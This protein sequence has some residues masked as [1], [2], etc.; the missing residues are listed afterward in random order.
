MEDFWTSALDFL[1]LSAFLIVGMI[2]KNKIRFLQKYLIPTSIIAGFIGLILG[3]EVLK[4]IDLDPDRLGV[5]IYH[6]MAVGFIALALKERRPVDGGNKR[7]NFNTGFAIVSSYLLQGIVGF[8]ISLLLAYTVFPDLFPPFG[9]LLPLGFGQGPGQAFSIGSSWELLGLIEG[10]NIGISIATIGFLW[11]IIFGIPLT[12]FLVR[13][14][15]RLGLVGKKTFI[16]KSSAKYE[17]KHTENI[18]KKLSLDSLAV[19]LA[20]IGFVYMLTYFLLKG[21]A[22][23][24]APLGTY[25]ETVTSLLWGFQFVIGTMIAIGVRVLLTVF[26]RKNWLH[27]NYPD[28]Y[29][30]QRVSSTS[31][32]YMIVA[33]ISAISIVTFR[34]NWIPILVIT[35]IGGIITIF[36]S[37]FLSRRIYSTYKVEH[38]VSLF[39]MLTGTI[40]T[41]VALLKEVDPDFKSNAAENLVLGSAVAL[42]LGLPLMFLL[43]FAVTGYTAGKPEFYF[44]TLGIFVLYMA[45]LLAVMLWK[46]KKR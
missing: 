17:E 40:T 29:I 21:I 10:G 3:Q 2:L 4:L 13:R 16:S 22:L 25:G 24:L 39:G 26:R 36:Y 18:P 34:A 20:L 30:L 35:T 14:K 5:L 46:R 8:A 43:G 7:D 28:N 15:K 42:P 45:I 38:V 11:A 12:N 23:A 37:L 6:L 19:Q 32:D 31:F 27:F 41:G 9:L 44:Y 33:A 1:Y